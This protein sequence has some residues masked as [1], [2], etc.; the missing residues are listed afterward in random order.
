MIN[1]VRKKGKR[2]NNAWRKKRSALATLFDVRVIE[3]NAESST[4]VA[5]EQVSQA[6]IVPQTEVIGPGQEEVERTAYGPKW[7]HGRIGWSKLKSYR[8]SCEESTLIAWFSFDIG[9]L[10]GSPTPNE[11]EGIVRAGHLPHLNQFP[12]D[13]AGKKFPPQFST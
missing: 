11:L 9:T 7:S 5:L 8:A 12:C 1:Q 4:E 6:N 13:D 2:D 3:Y 10:A